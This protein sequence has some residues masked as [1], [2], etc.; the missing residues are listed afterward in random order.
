[1]PPMPS[2]FIKAVKDICTINTF[3]LLNILFS[4]VNCLHFGFTTRLFPDT[5]NDLSIYE[6]L[7]LF[8]R[9]PLVIGSFFLS[10]LVAR[11]VVTPHIPPVCE[12]KSTRPSALAPGLFGRFH[13]EASFPWKRFLVHKVLSLEGNAHRQQQSNWRLRKEK[14]EVL[15]IESWC[16]VELDSEQDW[17]RT[18]K[19]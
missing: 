18:L 13:H 4:E 11:D 3:E 10:P 15:N 6:V 9:W 12:K 2:L 17:L 16:T 1:M 5:T 8:Y 19:T 14:E 7:K